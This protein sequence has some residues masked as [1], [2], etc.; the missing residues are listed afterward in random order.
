MT[1]IAC[2]MM[3]KDEDLLLRPWLLYHGYLFGFEN[4][5]VYDNGSKSTRIFETLRE[6]AD[7]GVHVDL[8]FT[9]QEDFE[10]KGAILG[11]KIKEFKN[12]DLYD[13]AIPLDCDEFL[14][15][16]D[17]NLGVICSRSLIRSEIGRIDRGGVVCR[18]SHCLD[19]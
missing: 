1:R 6:F 11:E 3:Q 18:V 19:N 13:I 17:F 14:A 12:S 8:S 9:R 15:I 4:L 2:L 5:Y 16:H 10:N 7:I